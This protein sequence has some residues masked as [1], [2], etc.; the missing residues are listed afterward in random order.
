MIQQRIILPWPPAALSPNGSQGDVFG[1]AKASRDY[2][3]T[4]TALLRERGKGI[5][6]LPAG[7]EVTRIVLTFCPPSRHRFDLDNLTRRCKPMLDAL[8]TA[9]GVDD[10]D[11]QSMLLER[12]DTCK[13]G[14]VIVQVY[15]SPV[16]EAVGIP[17]VGR[18][19]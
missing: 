12:G 17:L 2:K 10:G 11:W 3:A 18:V 4:C 15:T 9:I 5:S 13:N 14:G 16:V 19:S 1:K 6:R 8:A 7:A